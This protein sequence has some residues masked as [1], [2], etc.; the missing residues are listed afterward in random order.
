ML[1]FHCMQFTDWTLD[2]I[3]G[4][5][6]SPLSIC[7]V[8]NCSSFFVSKLGKPFVFNLVFTSIKTIAQRGLESLM[9]APLDVTEVVV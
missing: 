6:F 9:I 2:V 3:K 1:R 8:S 4:L 5:Q 7:Q